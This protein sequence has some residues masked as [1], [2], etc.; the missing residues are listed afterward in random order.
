VT[1]RPDTLSRIVGNLVDNALK[2]GTDVEI[3][4]E[5]DTGARVAI[6]VHDRGPGIPRAELTAVLQPF[7]RVDGSRSRATGGTGLGR[8]IVHQLALALR[9]TLTLTNREGGG[10]EA[11]VSLPTD[12]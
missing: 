6:V 10:L 7:Y 8:A 5:P 11:R 9:G 3:A 12:A 4:V 2:F 1:T